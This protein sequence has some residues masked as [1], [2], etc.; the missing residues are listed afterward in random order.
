MRALLQR[1]EPLPT[2]L[3]QPHEALR[4]IGATAIRP[5]LADRPAFDGLDR[6]RLYLRW[7][8][9]L[10]GTVAKGAL[11]DVFLFHDEAV[12]LAAGT[13]APA[14]EAA[15][16]EPENVTAEPE[17]VTAAPAHEGAPMRASAERHD[18]MME[19]ARELVIVGARLA[20]LAARS[21]DPQLV[22]IA[23]EIQGI[24]TG[25]RGTTMSIRMP[26]IGSISGRIRRLVHNRTPKRSKPIELKIEGQ[27]TELDKTVVEMLADPLT[28]F[29]QRR[30]SG[31]ADHASCPGGQPIRSLA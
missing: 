2:Y 15:R 19:R 6:E 12:E 8:V 22:A 16:P 11:R 1:H 24:P 21:D 14:V 31:A 4:G 17:N 18:D 20:E 28:R 9:R 29:T 3:A 27:D 10:Y 23:E 26:P 30:K 7:E 13:A 25:L 5:V